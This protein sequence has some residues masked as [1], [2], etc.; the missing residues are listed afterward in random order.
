[1]INYSD[2]L[3]VGITHITSGDLVRLHREGIFQMAGR[4]IHL[5]SEDK[6]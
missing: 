2:T 5:R 6:T 3:Y 1:M 4:T